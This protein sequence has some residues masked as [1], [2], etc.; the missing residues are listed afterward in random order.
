MSVPACGCCCRLFLKQARRHFFSMKN[1]MRWK[2]IVWKALGSTLK[3]YGG[4]KL[5]TLLLFVICATDKDC[6]CL[7]VVGCPSNNRVYLRDG[8]AQ[9]RSNF[10]SYIVIAYWHQANQ[11]QQSLYCQALQ[12]ASGVPMFKSLVWFDLDKSPQGKRESNLGLPLSRL[13]P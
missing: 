11:S 4:W 8:S 3:W 2:K 6:C 5:W 7:L 1:T 9:I 12:V 13:R 10:L